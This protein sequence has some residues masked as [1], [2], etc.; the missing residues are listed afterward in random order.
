[1]AVRTPGREDWGL[2]M[3]VK[4]YFAACRYRKIR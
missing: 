3:T 2:R 4:G 1:M